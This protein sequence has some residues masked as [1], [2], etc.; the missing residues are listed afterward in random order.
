VA[1]LKKDPAAPLLKVKDSL[2]LAADQVDAL[3][4]LSQE[5]SARA[6]AA[7]K[8]LTDWITRK[9]ARIF[10]Q[11]LSPKLAQARAALAKFQPEYDKKAKTMLTAEQNTRLT[12]L[13]KER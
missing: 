12:A 13:P 10:D 11:D 2:A 9:G 1:K 7:L 8:P 4:A 5:Y 3:A 6:D